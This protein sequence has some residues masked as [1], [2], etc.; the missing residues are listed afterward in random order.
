VIRKEIA[1]FLK[2]GTGLDDNALAS[3]HPGLQKFYNNAPRLMSCQLVAEVVKSEGC[4]ARARVGDRLVFDPYLNPEKS[5]GVMCPR[6]L[7]P[8]LMEVSGLWETTSGWPARPDDALP[9]IV[10]RNIRCLDPG[11]ADGGVGGI[12]YRIRLEKKERPRMGGKSS[13]EE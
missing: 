4:S 11:L 1:H 3:F 10:F 7:L 9:E 8:V 6:A 2:K 5:T 13:R 12:V